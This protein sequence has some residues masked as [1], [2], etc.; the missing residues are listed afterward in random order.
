MSFFDYSEYVFEFSAL[1]IRLPNKT[2]Q[3]KYYSRWME[4]YAQT[5]K[6]K[7]NFT[8][9]EW[10]L[11][12]HKSLREIFSSATF[13]VEAKK[14]LETKCFS[15][16][17]FCLYYSLFHAL[18]SSIFLDPQSDMNKLLNITHRNIINTFINAF[19]SSKEDIMNKSI[20]NIFKEFKY[21]REYYSYVTPF[22]NIFSPKEDIDSL[23]SILITS[24]QLTSFHSLMVGKSYDK[25]T[26][27]ITKL[28]DDSELYDFLSL[29]DDLFSKKDDIGKNKLDPSSM[30]L[31]DELLRYGFT[32]E[33]IAI[34]LEHQFDE[35][36]GYD[37]YSEEEKEYQLRITDIWS[38]VYNTLT[39]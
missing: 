30:Y 9:I 37:D 25:N 29:F 3:D 36:H 31:R 23:K 4:K 11:R 34:D 26:R 16:Y 10:T 14:N 7:D 32:P 8:G 33:Y 35:F 28:Y 22:N 13:F 21:K 5:F 17:Y 12:C 27:K 20:D 19:A 38:F 15:S 18:Y 6:S 24:Y 1:D 39:N 2:D